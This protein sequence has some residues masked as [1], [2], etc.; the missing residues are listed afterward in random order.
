[1]Y[2]VLF[3]VKNRLLFAIAPLT[4]VSKIFVLIFVQLD[5]NDAVIGVEVC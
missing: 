1:M 5:H 3:F 4:L 2:R